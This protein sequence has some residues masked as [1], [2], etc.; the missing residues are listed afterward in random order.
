MSR[1]PVLLDIS[2][3]IATVTLNEPERRNP[4]T[5]NDMI[6]ALLEIFAK[7]HLDPDISVMILTGADPA[8]CAGG[9]I[10]EMNDPDGVFRKEPLTAAQ[11]YVDGV[12]RL[13]QALYNMDIP[14][15]AAVNGA[16]VGAGCDLT[17]MC[18][19]RV[20]SENAMFGEVF[21][22]LGIIPGDAG[23]WF[24]L[25]RL[26]HQKAADLTFS[27]RMVGAEEALE[28]GMVLEVVPHDT[29]MDRARERAAVIAS[30]PP[31][32]VRVAKRLMRNAER[33]DLPDF[34]NSAAAYQALM[35]QTEDHH[36]AVAAFLEKRKPN[37]T[38]R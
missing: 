25:R 38:G 27:G 2:D 8:F 6:A 36:E 22:N 34:L 16:A 1:S 13:P 15:I 33:M 23:S 35:H 32:A 37:F 24:L 28:L 12:Q 19:M 30:K 20:A 31:R 4:V 3:R 14:T 18:D 5:G 17:M 7:V 9:D 21:I 11:S 26:G 29:L 10:K